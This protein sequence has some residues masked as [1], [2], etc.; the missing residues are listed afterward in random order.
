MVRSGVDLERVAS[1]FGFP[2]FGDWSLGRKIAFVKSSTFTVTKHGDG[3]VVSGNQRLAT[4]TLDENIF[5]EMFTCI[6]DSSVN[7]RKQA[8]KNGDI[9]SCIAGDMLIYTDTGSQQVG[10]MKKGTKILTSQ[11]GLEAITVHDDSYVGIAFCIN[12]HIWKL[13]SQPSMDV[14]GFAEFIFNTTNLHTERKVLV[15]VSQKEM[16]VARERAN[17][18]YLLEGKLR[19]VLKLNGKAE[20]RHRPDNPAEINQKMNFVRSEVIKRFPKLK[21]L[22]NVSSNTCKITIG[23]FP[24]PRMDK[25]RVFVAYP[26]IMHNTIE[27]IVARICTCVEYWNTFPEMRRSLSIE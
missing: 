6:P 19:T 21:F 22:C 5:H 24:R 17:F 16:V 26:F 27:E 10:F 15:R 14:H 23:P 11:T 13:Y 7:T 12:G 3:V 20:P 18:I 25:R 8:N 9:L 4:H 1:Y 2:M